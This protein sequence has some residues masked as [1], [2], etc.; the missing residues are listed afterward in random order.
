MKNLETP[1]K[2]GRVGR[3]EFCSTFCIYRPMHCSEQH[4]V[5]ISFFE[6]KAQQYFASLSYTFLYKKTLLKI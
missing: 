1:V 2:T 3:Y 4:F 6:V 5:T